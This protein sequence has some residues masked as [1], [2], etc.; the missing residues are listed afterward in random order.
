MTEKKIESSFSIF[1]RKGEKKRAR[2]WSATIVQKEGEGKKKKKSEFRTPEGK[3]GCHHAGR[4]GGK[5][6][7]KGTGGNGFLK[8]IITKKL[9]KVGAFCDGQGGKKKGEAG[10]DTPPKKGK[11]KRRE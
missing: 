3:G 1:L 9:K 6:G 2:R 7:E 10:Q 8:T 11:K 4:P 5:G